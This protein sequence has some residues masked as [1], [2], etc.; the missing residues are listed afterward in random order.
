[1]KTYAPHQL[2]ALFRILFGI[3]LIVVW[4]I[5]LPHAGKL[6][7]DVGTVVPLYVMDIHPWIDIFFVPFSWGWTYIVYILA[8]SSLVLFTLGWDMKTNAISISVYMLYYYQ[9]SFYHTP[10]LFHQALL[11]L[12][13]AFAFSE[14]D[15]TFS[16]RIKVEKGTWTA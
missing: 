4:A 7:S 3:V 2:L 15:N 13:I 9:L 10:S 5:Y 16:L 11:F 8:L 1:M 14:A 12:I 6:F